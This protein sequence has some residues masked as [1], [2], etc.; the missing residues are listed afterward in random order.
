[1]LTN[2]QSEAAGAIRMMDRRRFLLTA[3][4]ATAGAVFAATLLNVGSASAATVG[5]RLLE[6]QQLN[7][8]DSLRSRNGPSEVGA[9]R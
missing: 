1:M 5:Y 4:A 2:T 9:T 8:G 7:V 6:G 3:G